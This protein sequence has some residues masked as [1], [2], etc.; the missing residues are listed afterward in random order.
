MKVWLW[1]IKKTKCLKDLCIILFFKLLSI[2][3][4]ITF[5]L[6]MRRI[7]DHA[8]IQDHT[9]LLNS[10]VFIIILL[11]QIFVG[12]VIYN[13]EHRL[14]IDIDKKLKSLKIHLFLVM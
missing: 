9:F 3:L 5:A 12:A 8:L 7:I 11:S 1:L 14:E 10:L 4:G 2:C 13:L 6:W